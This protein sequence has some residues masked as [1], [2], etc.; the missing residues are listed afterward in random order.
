MIKTLESSKG[1]KKTVIELK[2]N[3]LIL[4]TSTTKNGKTKV[5]EKA[6]K[7]EQ[8]AKI[9]FK[10][11]VVKLMKKGYSDPKNP[12]SKITF[13]PSIYRDPRF[14]HENT[15]EEIFYLAQVDRILTADGTNLYLWDNK[16]LLLSKFKFSSDPYF[17][18]AIMCKE[19]PSSNE[20]VVFIGK[21]RG[22]TIYL[23]EL[24]K[25]ELKLIKQKQLDLGTGYYYDLDIDKNIYIGSGNVV[26]TLNWKLDE[27]GHLDKSIGDENGLALH[28]KSGKMAFVEYSNEDKD[29]VEVTDLEGNA[30]CKFKTKVHGSFGVN[31]Q[32]INDGTQ[33]IVSS[34]SMYQTNLE[35]WDAKKG[36]QIKKLQNYS[37]DGGV[38]S[39]DIA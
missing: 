27:V 1:N 37:S 8:K 12:H 31:I 19:R 35:I 23:F 24:E 10:K 11:E 33:I 38:M 29:S 22:K 20:L 6:L 4:H 2:L 5:K 7:D 15:V 26:K 13:S 25:D 14:A 18:G 17:F 32:F 21:H 30:I 9:A 39:M 3:G 16:G 28:V 36:K 34:S